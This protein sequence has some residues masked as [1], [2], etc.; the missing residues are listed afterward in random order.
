MTARNRTV[1]P[2]QKNR[3][4]HGVGPTQVG[5]L[6]LAGFTILQ[7]AWALT[8]PSA[9][10]TALGSPET[11]VSQRI[12]DLEL[13][14]T[15]LEQRLAQLER[16][17]RPDP[18]RVPLER[19][20]VVLDHPQLPPSSPAADIPSSIP[21]TED[22]AE[23]IAGKEWMQTRVAREAFETRMSTE[24]EDASWSSRQEARILDDVG[25]GQLGRAYL[26]DAQCKATLCRVE[27]EHPEA[28]ELDRLMLEVMSKPSFAGRQS[29]IEQDVAEAGSG[30]MT[31]FVA[32]AGHPL[33]AP[34]A[35]DIDQPAARRR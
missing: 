26:L 19:R 16:Q 14:L 15:V 28:S 12:V 9:G 11:E 21:E 29:F 13:K 2:A 34:S 22:A 5:L 27:L 7:N 20:P 33:K 10:A 1:L 4:N 31:V 32:R 35:D 3:R 24:T 18:V 25:Q 23:N 8:A 30:R 6:L 17:P